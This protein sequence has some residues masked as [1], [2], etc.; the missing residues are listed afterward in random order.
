LGKAFGA[1]IKKPGDYFGKMNLAI[2][3]FFSAQDLVGKWVDNSYPNL[4]AQILY[5]LLIQC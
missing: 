4:P 1:V 3:E 2:G 5:A